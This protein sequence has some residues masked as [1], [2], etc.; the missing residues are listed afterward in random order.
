VPFALCP[1]RGSAIMSLAEPL[2]RWLTGW[3]GRRQVPQSRPMP[4]IGPGQ[5]G[6][7]ADFRRWG[8]LVGVVL[9]RRPEGYKRAVDVEEEQRTRRRTNHGATIP[10]CRR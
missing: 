4:G 8:C 7:G 5:E 2:A 9:L 10:P 3:P 1:L 6:I